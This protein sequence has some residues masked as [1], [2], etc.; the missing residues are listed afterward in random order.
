[1][2]DYARHERVYR[3]LLAA[4]QRQELRERAA[5]T[6]TI[7][8]DALLR[9]LVHSIGVALQGSEDT[10]HAL[11]I[12]TADCH[13]RAVSRR[14][15]VEDYT[16]PR[17]KHPDTLRDEADRFAASWHAGVPSFEA[18][19]PDRADPFHQRPA[20]HPV[21]SI[22]KCIAPGDHVSHIDYTA[23][24][25]EITGWIPEDS[26]QEEEVSWYLEPVPGGG[27]QLD[28][29]QAPITHMAVRLD[30]PQPKQRAIDKLAIPANTD[31]YAAQWLA[32]GDQLRS[33][34][35]LD[36]ARIPDPEQPDTPR[37]QVSG[38]SQG[39]ADDEDISDASIDLAEAAANQDRVLAPEWEFT[40]KRVEYTAPMHPGVPNEH[41]YRVDRNG[42][43]Q[44]AWT[45]Y[46][47]RPWHPQYGWVGMPRIGLDANYE[48]VVHPKAWRTRLDGDRIPV[49]GRKQPAYSEFTPWLKPGE[50]V[51][52]THPRSKDE[53]RT[54]IRMWRTR[55]MR[56]RAAGWT[57]HATADWR[58]RTA[59]INAPEPDANLNL[60]RWL[61]DAQTWE[62]YQDTLDEGRPKPRWQLREEAVTR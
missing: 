18:P 58:A 1:M 44:P 25:A 14:F 26:W 52:K 56:K 30:W 55:I 60:R 10:A 48:P 13:A 51:S 38:F 36:P 11:A 2:C 22:G 9:Q 5:T 12:N 61:E 46:V 4:A 8:P 28:W 54:M 31:A 34:L 35:G 23:Y 42:T 3:T 17:Y 50:D 33:E 21:A 16:A 43:L 24:P 19:A 27:V 32:S 59:S 47:T 41:A 20:P 40:F 62:M 45:R 49:P 29:D 6:S 57:L 7:T 15:L 37:A 39:D 53:R